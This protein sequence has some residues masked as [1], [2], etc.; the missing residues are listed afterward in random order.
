[1]RKKN[2]MTVNKLLNSMLYKPNSAS[3]KTANEQYVSRLYLQKSTV[4]EVFPFNDPSARLPIQTN[5]N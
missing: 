1:M 3:R 4:I 5:S 2:G